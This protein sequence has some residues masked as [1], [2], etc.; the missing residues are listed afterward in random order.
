M[1]SLGQI[2]GI[3]D[4]IYRHMSSNSYVTIVDLDE[5]ITP[6]HVMTI[7]ELMLVHERRG[8]MIGSFVF[9]SCVFCLEYKQDIFPHYIP[10]F[11]TQ[12]CVRRENWIYPFLIRTKYIVKPSRVIM[13]GVHHVWNLCLV[14]RGETS[15][16][17]SSPGSSLQ[18]S[19]VSWEQKD[20]GK[21][22]VDPMSRKYL[23]HLL[24]SKA[25]KIWKELF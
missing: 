19:S 13:A 25:V 6:R 12:T 24:R 10:H 22:E 16:C 20:G 5:F 21:S 1:W 9:R 8:R 7:Q 23:N 3:N 2:A 17:K 11:I 4:C 15:S 18:K 14:Q